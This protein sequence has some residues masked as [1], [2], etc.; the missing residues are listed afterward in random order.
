MTANITKPHGLIVDDEPNLIRV[1]KK[2]FIREGYPNIIRIKTA[3]S[4]EKAINR[5]QEIKDSGE[6]LAWLVS[7]MQMPQMK[8][9]E[10]AKA[11]KDI[12]PNCETAILT[13]ESDFSDTHKAILEGRISEHFLKEES[14]SD[15]FRGVNRMT[16][17]YLVNSNRDIAVVLRGLQNQESD[18]QAFHDFSGGRYMVWYQEGWVDKNPQWVD[19]DEYDYFS[20]MLTAFEKRVGGLETFAGGLRRTHPFDESGNRGILDM[21]MLLSGF[22]LEE[23]ALRLH[24]EDFRAEKK[25]EWKIDDLFQKGSEFYSLLDQAGIPVEDAFKS[26]FSDIRFE[27]DMENGTI[28]EYNM[29]KRKRLCEIPAKKVHDQRGELTPFLNSIVDNGRNYAEVG[30]LGILGK[31][32]GDYHGIRLNKRLHEEIAAVFLQEGITDGII[33]CNPLHY[34]FFYKKMGFT[35][36]PNITEED[37]YKINAPSMAYH[38]DLKNIENPGK[39]NI[40]SSVLN[41]ILAYKKKLD[42]RKKDPINHPSCMCANMIECLKTDYLKPINESVNYHCPIRAQ[43][44][45]K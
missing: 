24:E 10:V 27:I 34:K 7:D 3:G 45:L 18:M 9:Y 25:N 2:S 1:Y 8:G 40:R 6:E 36:I 17:N 16:R 22:K 15:L 20:Y 33:C 12:F 23:S 38:L 13:G 37:Y 29:E 39:I 32:R 43:E 21:L 4:G 31:F 11:V 35:P 14:T 19:M 41:R 42:L 28:T 44:F 26:M 5:A 30:R